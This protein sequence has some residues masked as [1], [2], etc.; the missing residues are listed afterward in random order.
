MWK[1][2]S[3]GGNPGKWHQVDIPD[4]HVLDQFEQPTVVAGPGFMWTFDKDIGRW[5]QLPI[6]KWKEERSEDKPIEVPAGEGYMWK[7]YQENGSKHWHQVRMSKTDL[8]RPHPEP[9]EPAGNGFRWQY[10]TDSDRNHWEQVLVK[11]A[12]CTGVLCHLGLG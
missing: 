4:W 9:S 5:T 6:P 10:N 3:V 11:K 8:L 7:F 12:S 2:S 1:F